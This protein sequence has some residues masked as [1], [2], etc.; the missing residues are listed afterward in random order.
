VLGRLRARDEWKFFAVL[1]RADRP[2]AIGWWLVLF[3]RGTLPALFAVAMG[4]LVGAVQH[5]SS[6]LVPLSLVGVVFVLL[7]VLTPIHKR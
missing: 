3:L 4:A 1:P 5:G 7:Q 6:L 2:L